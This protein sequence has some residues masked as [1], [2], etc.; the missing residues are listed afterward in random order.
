MKKCALLFLMLCLL[1][2]MGYAQRGQ[3]QMLKRLKSATVR[4]MV[5]NAKGEQTSAGSGFFIR[6]RQVITNFHVIRGGR[7]AKIKIFDNNVYKVRSVLAYDAEYDLA[8]LDVDIPKS[9]GTTVLSLARKYPREGEKVIALGNPLDDGFAFSDGIISAIKTYGDV[10]KMLQFTAPISPGNSGGPLVNMAGEVLGVVA[11]YRKDGQNFNYA[12]PSERVEILTPGTPIALADLFRNDANASEKGE[13]T[14]PTEKFV[15]YNWMVFSRAMRQAGYYHEVDRDT[16]KLFFEN[17]R[18]QYET[19][20][21]AELLN[22]FVAR[23]IIGKYYR[24]VASPDEPYVA[25]NSSK[26]IMDLMDR[27]IAYIEDSLLFRVALVESDIVV[28]SEITFFKVVEGGDYGV[29]CLADPERVADLDLEAYA[30]DDDGEWQ[31]IA[32][33]EESDAFPLVR[34]VAKKSGIIRLIIKVAQY[35]K[36]FDDSKYGLVVWQP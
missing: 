19:D 28:N 7:A 22:G 33:D 1:L 25:Y 34:L 10:G 29:F 32:K 11:S 21:T 12:I 2:S 13:A 8:L 36:S 6:D 18:S 30:E 4:I 20:P 27:Y 3:D 24:T 23:S 15:A 9:S 26:P 5:Y 31:L 35:K 14:D 16:M 17:A